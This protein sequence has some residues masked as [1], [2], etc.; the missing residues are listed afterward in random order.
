MPHDTLHI[1]TM[2]LVLSNYYT[3]HVQWIIMTICFHTMS[4]KYINFT[5]DSLLRLNN[6]VSFKGIHNSRVYY[7]VGYCFFS[8]KIKINVSRIVGA[9]ISLWP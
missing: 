6:L 7:S 8:L 4:A 3:D 9:Q 5:L 2:C 1:F